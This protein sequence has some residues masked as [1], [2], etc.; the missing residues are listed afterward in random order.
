MEDTLADSCKHHH[1]NPHHAGHNQLHGSLNN[2]PLVEHSKIPHLT[3]CEVRDYYEMI[4]GIYFLIT[5][6]SPVGPRF[7]STQ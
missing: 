4:I 7:L 1:G 6:T 2:V 5:M 3:A